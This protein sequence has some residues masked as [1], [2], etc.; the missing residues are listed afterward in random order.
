MCSETIWELCFYLYI[1]QPISQW[2]TDIL[3][4]YSGIWR[5]WF[6][7]SGTPW[8]GSHSLLFWWSQEHRLIRTASPKSCWLKV[9]LN[10]SVLPILHSQVRCCPV[11]LLFPE[12]RCFVSCSFRNKVLWILSTADK[13]SLAFPNQ[14]QWFFRRA[15]EDER[16]LGNQNLGQKPREKCS[17]QSK[18]K[19]AVIWRW[20]KL[21]HFRHMGIENLSRSRAQWGESCIRLIKH[22]LF[23]WLASLATVTCKVDKK[24]LKS[25]CQNR[26]T[27][28]LLIFFLFLVF[29]T[30]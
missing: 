6:L 19:P 27:F 13:T 25:V 22:F 16:S 4:C 20:G 12:L 5:D 28:F 26:I 18:V 21:R 2:H 1:K 9:V 7:N 10:L 14:L 8:E 24:K 17:L 15:E 3:G 23:Q 30:V 11:F 29:I